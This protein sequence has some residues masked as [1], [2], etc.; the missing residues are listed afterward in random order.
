M[1]PTP[2]L[3]S[4]HGKWATVGERRPRKRSWGRNI[5]P[6]LGASPNNELDLRRDY[7]QGNQRIVCMITEPVSLV[8]TPLRMPL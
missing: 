1:L 3:S 6:N 4:R 5:I 8:A 2:V 7:G